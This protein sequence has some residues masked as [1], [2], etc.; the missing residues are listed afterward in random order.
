MFE[1][2]VV[3]LMHVVFKLCFSKQINH[4]ILL[5]AYFA[6]HTNQSRFDKAE[7]PKQISECKFLKADVAEQI[8]PAT[9]AEHMS[10]SRCLVD[11]AKCFLVLEQ[12]LFY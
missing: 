8:A 3:C 1:A 2:F 5:K 4:T 9:M 6:E 7:L 12:I 11:K 10:Q